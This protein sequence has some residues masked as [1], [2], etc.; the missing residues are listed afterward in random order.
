MEAHYRNDGDKVGTEVEKIRVKER[1]GGGK[2][3]RKKKEGEEM[4]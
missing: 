3:A 1:K 2:G 4:E